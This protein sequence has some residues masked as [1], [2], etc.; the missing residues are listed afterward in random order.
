MQINQHW[1]DKQLG[2]NLATQEVLC[3]NFLQQ[4]SALN[5]KMFGGSG[6]FHQC[7]SNLVDINQT[8]VQG[9]L[10][11]NFFSHSSPGTMVRAIN[12]LL[13]DEIS[14]AYLAIN[15]YSF[16]PVNDLNI[17]YK[18]SMDDTVDQ[19]VGFLNKPFVRVQHNIPND[20]IHFVGIHGLDIFTYEH[21]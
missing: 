7:V 10:F 13:S 3:L 18:D 20:N 6:Y 5:W 16:V 9:L 17:C 8:N 15:R 19:I 1:R 14:V 12:S 21:N 2:S 11:V 4:Y